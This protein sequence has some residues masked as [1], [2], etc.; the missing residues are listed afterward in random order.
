[1][2]KPFDATLNALIDDHVADWAAFLAARC[3]VPMGAVTSLDTDLSATLQPDRLF[4]VDG[5][6]PAVLHLELES[7]SRLGIPRDLLRYNAFVHHLTGLPVYSVLVLLRPRANASDQTGEY[8]VR[9]ARGEELNRLAYT[10]VR[11][12]QESAADRLAAGPG[13]APLAVLT[14]EAA[15]DLPAAFVRLRD[16]LHATGMPGNVQESVVASS[17]VLC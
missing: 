8:T 6:A 12:W 4:R 3:G 15:A 16:R 10:V 11:V 7:S 9:G 14:N 2:G 5:P 13:V 1:V 17:F